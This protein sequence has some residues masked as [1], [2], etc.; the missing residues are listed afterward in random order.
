MRNVSTIKYQELNIKKTILALFI[1]FT[2]L[3]L[4]KAQTTT[5]KLKNPISSIKVGLNYSSLTN[6]KGA[7]Y[8][9]GFKIGVCKEWD[10]LPK[11]TIESGLLFTYIRGSLKGIPIDIDEV[12]HL[13]RDI[14]SYDANFSDGYIEIPLLVK[15]NIFRNKKQKIKIRFSIG[16]S[17]YINHKL[18]Y[19]L[20]FRIYDN[21]SIKR[22]KYLFTYAP[23]P[24]GDDKT[25]KFQYVFLTGKC[26]SANW[27]N[28]NIGFDVTWSQFMVEILYTWVKEELEC[29]S[30]LYGLKKTHTFS[31]LVVYNIKGFKSK[32]NK[33]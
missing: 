31:F 20:S 22:K 12:G 17:F 15:F 19:P 29:V 26:F 33:K 3:S 16:P 25:R 27:M 11:L 5:G 18:P 28:Y 32:G 21:V 4:L 9:F 10:I 6:T 13:P 1:L 2:F 24:Y 30:Y 8:D 14:Y 23:Y 7:E